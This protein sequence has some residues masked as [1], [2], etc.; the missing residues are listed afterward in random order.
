MAVDIDIDQSQSF[1]TAWCVNVNWFHY[2]LSAGCPIIRT[3]QR[4]LFS[5][6]RHY[7][8]CLW[9]TWTTLF[10]AADEPWHASTA[11]ISSYISFHRHRNSN[12]LYNTT[13]SFRSFLSSPHQSNTVPSYRELPPNSPTVWSRALIDHM[14]VQH[15]KEPTL[16]WN[17]IAKLVCIGDSSTGKSRYKN[18]IP[19]ARQMA[20]IKVWQHDS[21]KDVSAPIM[22]LL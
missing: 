22:M 10:P 21:A 4:H 17:Y 9:S 6:R 5:G 20:N 16:P 13:V 14:P 1:E 3:G 7:P 12:I 8:K 15:T 18:L 19:A 2:R 11:N